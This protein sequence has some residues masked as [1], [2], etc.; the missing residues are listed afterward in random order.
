M[1]DVVERNWFDKLSRALL[2]EPKD[3]AQLITLLHEA[4]SRH[5][6]ESDALMMIE[7]VL[8]VSEMR[9]GDIMIPR[10]Q[11]VVVQETQSPADFLEQVIESGHSRFPV[12]SKHRDEV[13]GILLAKDLLGLILH[14][15]K[16]FNLQQLLRP[17]IV[18]PESK[19]LNLLLEE[20]Q[21][22]RYHMAIV[23]DEYGGVSGLITI[24]DI[25]EQIVGEI[26]DEYDFDEED[27]IKA[28]EDGDYIIKA[29]T[30]IEDFNAYFNT[31]FS[32][33]EF[34]TIGGLVIHAFGY[35][36]R[37]GESTTLASFKFS[38]LNANKRHV[39]L[40]KMTK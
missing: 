15:D 12:I 2:R 31:D 25:L 16:K 9:A 39:R 40:L 7:G 35:L 24:E 4:E 38:V 20:F 3:R 29:H 1:N 8:Q 17:A 28:H 14:Q 30:P 34:D 33:Q 37:R 23:V 32:S 5:L 22:Q 19:P 18:I 36:P 26:E 27:E 13:I 10:A 11:M 21:M 6:L